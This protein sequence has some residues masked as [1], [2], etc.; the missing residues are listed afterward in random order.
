MR[1]HL[2]YDL[3]DFYDRTKSSNQW[4]KNVPKYGFNANNSADTPE[5]DWWEMAIRKMRDNVQ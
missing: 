2:V 1:W 5:V 4:D 3:F